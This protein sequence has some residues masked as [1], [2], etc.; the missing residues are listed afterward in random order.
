MS[1][2]DRTAGLLSSPMMYSRMQLVEFQRFHDLAN[3]SS[4]GLLLRRW[5]FLPAY[6][7]FS[8]I[9]LGLGWLAVRYKYAVLSRDAALLGNFPK[10]IKFH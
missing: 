10:F 3:T 6:V 9:A 5:R 8:L 4:L 1:R 7:R 2:S